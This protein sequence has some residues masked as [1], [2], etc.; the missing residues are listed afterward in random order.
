MKQMLFASLLVVAAGAS[1]ALAQGD[2]AA[3][4]L[5]EAR[6]ALG[7]ED[8]LRAVKTLEAAGEFRRTF[9]EA[10]MDGEL[11]ILIETP[12]KLRRNEDINMPG[13]GLM[14]RTEVLNGDEVWDDSGQRGGMGHSM[15]MM[16]GPGG[17][18]DPE[19][20]KEM[21]RR[22]RRGDL[23]RLSLAWLLTSDAKVTHA[24]VA[25]APDGKADVLEFT[26]ADGP[27]MRLFIDQKTH[28][29]LMITWQGPEPRMMMRR[30]GPGAGG[31]DAES[32]AREAA[33]ADTAPPRQVTFEMR[34]EGY[35]AVDGIQLPHTIT[36]GT[37]G[38]V[39]DEWTVKSYKINPA[40]KPNTFTK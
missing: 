20:L 27:P 29:P 14:T 9:G 23:A 16:R 8:K 2:R 40:F 1:P 3:T 18:A 15:I 13:G 6:K 31:A 36:R 25:E 34:L 33:A 37:N 38:Q 28:M 30:A 11:E 5:A 17:D 26:A 7:G 10:Q 19:R 39:N 22:M 35:R 4:V 24:G 12:D 32:S 21:Q